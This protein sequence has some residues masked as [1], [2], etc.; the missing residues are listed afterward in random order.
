L[1][2][3]WLNNKKEVVKNLKVFKN[4]IRLPFLL[5]LGYVVIVVTA[6]ISFISLFKNG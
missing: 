3:N 6:I 5:A 2:K 4:I 1:L